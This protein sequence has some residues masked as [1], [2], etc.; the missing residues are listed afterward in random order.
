MYTIKGK[1]IAIAINIDGDGMQSLE[2]SN[3]KA[4]EILEGLLSKAYSRRAVA[5]TAASKIGG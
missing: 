4:I 3:D 1:P 5:G 2:L